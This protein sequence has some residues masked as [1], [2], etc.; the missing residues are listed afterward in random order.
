MGSIVH[1][2]KGKKDRF[3]PPFKIFPYEELAEVLKND[4]T[5]FIEDR[6][7]T[8]S[9]KR[10][11][12]WKASKKLS[13]MLGK[14]VAYKKGFMRLDDGDALEGYLFYIEGESI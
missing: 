5:A 14:K 1:R 8:N 9:F 7:T 4:M 12:V 11:T 2:I 10:G 13:D 3:Y 6:P